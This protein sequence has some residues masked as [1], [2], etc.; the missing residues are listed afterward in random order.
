MSFM[1]SKKELHICT[2]LYTVKNS[3]NRTV[4]DEK[5]YNHIYILSLQINN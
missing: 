1:Y 2:A 5:S 3:T 4:D